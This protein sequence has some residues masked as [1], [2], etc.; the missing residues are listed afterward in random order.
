MP[1]QSHHWRF[2]FLERRKSIS[3]TWCDIF[4]WKIRNAAHI[5]SKMFKPL[6]FAWSS[7]VAKF[8]CCY[9]C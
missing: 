5:V 7:T 4:F 2:I 1:N 3:I 9:C 8:Y 6:H